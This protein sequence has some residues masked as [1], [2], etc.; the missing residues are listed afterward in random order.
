[1]ASFTIRSDTAE[2]VQEVH[3]VLKPGGKAIIIDLRKDTPWNEITSYVDR[4]NLSKI[5]SWITKMT[6]KHMLLKRA[7]TKEGMESLVAKS[8]FKSSEI[9]E[10]P[11][12]MEVRLIRRKPSQQQAA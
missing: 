3:R 12:G 4:M 11:V 10:A 7:Y 2:A 9:V 8:S 1:M 6:F 5:N